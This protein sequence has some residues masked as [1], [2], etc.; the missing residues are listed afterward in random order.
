MGFVNSMGSSNEMVSCKFETRTE[1]LNG[2]QERVVAWST[3]F[4]KDCF[5]WEGSAAESMV[6]ERFKADVEAVVLVDYEDYSTV[7]DQ[8]RVTVNSVEY[9]VIHADNVAFQNVPVVI[10]VKAYN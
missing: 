8:D 2:D 1:T 5:F 7:K 3:N 9:S 6:S 4:T 10:A